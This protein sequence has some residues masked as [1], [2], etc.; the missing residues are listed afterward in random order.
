MEQG[1]YSKLG[2]PSEPKKYSEVVEGIL[3]Q[4]RDDAGRSVS[5][6]NEITQQKKST[7]KTSR[8]KTKTTKLKRAEGGFVER[9]TYD[10]VYTNG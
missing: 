2:V 10:W 1:L 9:N 5:Q 6:S 8:A 3:K 4:R 7:S